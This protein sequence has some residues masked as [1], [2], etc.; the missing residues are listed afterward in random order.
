M[1]RL[2][3]ASQLQPGDVLAEEYLRWKRVEE[4]RRHRTWVEVWFLEGNIAMTN[5]KMV[6]VEDRR[7]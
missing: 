6:E 7:D 3:R 1:S 5:D 2:K 4:V